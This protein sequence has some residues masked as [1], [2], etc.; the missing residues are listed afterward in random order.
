MRE[1]ALERVDA[2]RPVLPPSPAHVGPAD[3]DTSTP[4]RTVIALIRGGGSRA[5]RKL[6]FHEAAA[7]GRGLRLRTNEFL[8]ILHGLREASGQ[9]IGLSSLETGHGF[10]R[11]AAES[12][13]ANHHFEFR[14]PF[15]DLLAHGPRRR[16]RVRRQRRDADYVAPSSFN[17]REHFI[18]RRPDDGKGQSREPLLL[19]ELSQHCGRDLIGA[20]MGRKTEYPGIKMLR[21]VRYRRGVFLG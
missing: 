21:G 17:Q 2:L 9:A 12:P 4:W 20:I 16:E 13:D 11:I 14:E 6:T 8:N 10:L 15:P 3:P 7:E 19:Q 1:L 5:S 18:E